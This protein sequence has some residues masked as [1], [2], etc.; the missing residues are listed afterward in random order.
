MGHWSRTAQARLTGLIKG[1]ERLAKGGIGA[2]VGKSWLTRGFWAV[3]DQGLFATSNFALNILLARWLTPYEY[4]AFSLAFA[5]FLFVGCLH[6]ATLTEP[7]LVFG[8]GRYEGRLS[9][10]LGALVYGHLGFAALGSIALLLASLGFGLW[11]SSSLAA[12]LLALA[13]AGPFILLLWL[14]RRACYVRFEPHLAALGGAYYMVLMLAGAYV[15]Y[16]FGWLSTA[17]A[18]GVMGVSSLAVSVWLA[19]RLRVKLP[20]LRGSGLTRNCIKSHWEYGRWSVA[21]RGLYWFPTNIYYLILPVW[22]GLEA[23][24]SFKAL[25]NLIMPMLQTVSALT[26]ILLPALVRARKQGKVGSTMRLALVPLVLASVLYW[27]FLGVFH[28]P[29][30]SLAYGGQY[31]EYAD[32]LWILGLLP[33]ALAANEVLSQALRAL[34][35]PDSLFRAYTLYAIIGGALGIGC[36][37]LWGIVGAVVGILVSRVVAVVLVAAALR[38]LHR[39]SPDSWN[40]AQGEQEIR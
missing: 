13:L 30:V 20:P 33:V 23:G 7:M 11:G 18:L 5:I 12:V 34:E 40:V 9:E 25:M 26:V 16:R 17:T 10:Y 37:Y 32:L 38:L 35:R 1:P 8:P 39:R 36:M 24:A 29:V 4:G 31:A 19:A 3:M 2:K 14:M 28:D 27:V 22:G 21:N 15:L 6:T